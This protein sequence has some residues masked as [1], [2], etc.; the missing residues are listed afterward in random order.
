MA[1]RSSSSLTSRTFFK[2]LVVEASERRFLA[3]AARV[4]G[5]N[6]F[7]CYRT[8]LFGVVS[9]P[10][11]WGRLAAL[12][13]RM[14]A[15]LTS[16]RSSTFQCYVDDPLF[17]FL[18]SKEKRDGSA[19]MILLLWEALGLKLSWKKGAKGD[20]VEWIGAELK[21][22]RDEHGKIT[23]V[24]VTITEDKAKK[25]QATITAIL[26]E[27]VLIRRASLRAF[28]GLC[29]WVSSV[30]P[31][32]R[33]FCQML[34]AATTAP[35]AGRESRELVSRARVKRPLEWI[36]E[37]TSRSLV[38]LPRSFP[39]CRSVAGPVLGFDAS[40]TGGGA[41]LALSGGEPS[42]YLATAWT[43]EDEKLLGA[44]CGDPASQAVWETYALLLAIDAW[45]SELSRHGGT[46][47]LRGDAQ[48]VLQ[49]VLRRRAKSPVINLLVA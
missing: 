22:A 48:G 11:V 8:V 21:F 42:E 28:A 6:G 17:S 46:L 40:T 13:M 4:K 19:A 26:R 43:K 33:P 1:T 49:A 23:A 39:V 24:V 7:F 25:M 38:S 18:G 36:Q 16:R 34:W 5:Q 45:S 3:G 9:G 27:G 37:F 10:L 29:S 31:V 32:L 12:I 20:Q 35:P 2:Q 47:E 15:A 44:T 14:T 30:T 41:W